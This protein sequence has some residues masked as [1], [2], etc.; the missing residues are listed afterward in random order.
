MSDEGVVPGSSALAEL[1]ASL[2]AEDSVI[3]PEVVDA[4]GPADLGALVAAGTRASSN[5][6]QYSLVV[7]TVREGY[8][9]HY[10][11]PRI[12]RDTIDP[13]LALLAGDY[14]YANALERLAAL[15]DMEAVAELSDLISLSAQ[16]HTGQEG[17]A[18]ADAENAAGLWLSSVLAIG[19]G[20]NPAHDAAK[21]AL[22]GEA[23]EASDL[24]LKAIESQPMGTA[25]GPRLEAAKKTVGFRSSNR[26]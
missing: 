25:I 26:G 1:A 6:V 15:G 20:S 11:S 22:R 23:P 9:L 24:L 3:S 13:D 14:L 7:E 12:L 16:L 8:L 4:T 19:F 2:R 17:A 5:P 10:G 18:S 21:A